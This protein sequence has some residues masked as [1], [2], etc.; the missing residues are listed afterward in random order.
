MS[1]MKAIISNPLDGEK[2][3]WKPY[4]GYMLLVVFGMSIVL[5]VYQRVNGGPI[6]PTHSNPAVVYDEAKLQYQLQDVSKD[7]NEDIV[8][9]EAALQEVAKAALVALQAPLPLSTSID[10]PFFVQAPDGVWDA[11][12]MNASEEASFAMI[13]A[14]LRPETESAVDVVLRA[15][16]EQN[17]AVQLSAVEFAAFVEA[18]DATI[19]ATV[20]AD[21]TQEEMRR[22]LAQ[23]TPIIVP[24]HGDV[25][26]N[27]FFI[28]EGLPHHYLVVRGYDEEFFFTNDPGTRRG[29]NYPYRQTILM[30]AMI[31]RQVIILQEKE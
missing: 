12:H 19:R 25:L 20:I 18:Y 13:Y 31:D 26:E 29:E 11:L 5:Y 14:M 30:D 8:N 22:Y 27:P 16:Q 6:L 24:T 10:V 15:Q 3:P 23:G 28:S 2:K 21:P 4:Y 17:I 9:T 7:S 1:I